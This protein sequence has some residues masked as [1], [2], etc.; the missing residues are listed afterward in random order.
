MSLDFGPNRKRK[1]NTI[2]EEDGVRT[3]EQLCPDGYKE[4]DSYIPSSSICPW[5]HYG[6]SHQQEIYKLFTDLGLHPIK[7]VTNRTK[8]Y[9]IGSGPNGRVRFGDD[10]LPSIYRIALPIT[11][12]EQYKELNHKV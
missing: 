2:T 12:I 5:D 3:I 4:V 10:M 11:E 1:M 8:I 6:L 9:P 7:L